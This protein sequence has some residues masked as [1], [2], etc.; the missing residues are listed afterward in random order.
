MSTPRSADLPILRDS[1]ELHAGVCAYA[2][3]ATRGTVGGSA[4]SVDNI[5]TDLWQDELGDVIQFPPDNGG[6]SLF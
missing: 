5:P 6:I 1:S 3:A 2:G 4:L